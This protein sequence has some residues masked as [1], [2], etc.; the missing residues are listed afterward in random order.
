MDMI[1]N[2]FACLIAKYSIYFAFVHADCLN[3]ILIIYI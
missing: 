3:N 1:N 2:Y